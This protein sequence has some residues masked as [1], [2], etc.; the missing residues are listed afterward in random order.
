MAISFQRVRAISKSIASRKESRS[1]EQRKSSEV[2]PYIVGGTKSKVGNNF[3]VEI[4]VYE[5]V[6]HKG[7]LVSEAK[8]ENTDLQ[9][10]FDNAISVITTNL[11]EKNISSI[12]L[13]TIDEL[14]G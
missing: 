12:T 3:V 13:P 9:V 6:N 4:Y 8:T 10:A 2:L 14:R 5:E 11:S 7:V 1:N